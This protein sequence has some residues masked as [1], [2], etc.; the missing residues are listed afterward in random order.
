MNEKEHDV[1]KDLGD[2]LI[3]RR[4]TVEDA[5]ALA[6][7]NAK[8]HSD[9]GPE[10]PDNRVAVWVRDLMT[11]PHPTSGPGDFTIVE[12]TRK[13]KIVS[14]MN[15]IPQT[16]SYA[17]VPFGVGRPELVGTH[18][19]Y[20]KRG[21]VRAQFEVVHR[22]SAERGHKVQA[23]TG[24]PYYYRQFGYEMGLG[25]GGGRIGYTANIPMLEDD[26]EEP[27]IIRPAREADLPFIAELYAQSARRQLLSCLR[28]DP[29]WRYELL[30]KSKENLN[31]LELRLIEDS[32]G[33]PLGFLG[34]PF[35]LWGPT[36][37]V[38]IYELK[39]GTSWLQVTPSVLRYLQKEG[40]AYAAQKEGVEFQA[41]GFWTGSEHPVYEAIQDRLPRKRHPYAWYVRVPD[42]P[43]FLGHIKPVLE[44]R[45]AESVLVG[46]SGD[47]KL[48]MYR[49]GVKLA[50]EKGELKDVVAYTPEHINDGDVFFPGLTFLRLLFGYNDFWELEEMFPDC[51][52][53][54]DQG[55]ALTPILFPKQPSNLWPLA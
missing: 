17:G 13:G 52:A 21:L 28:D 49:N 54:N 31:K 19:D 37:V 35:S 42:L 18:P 4:A 38:Y 3:L 29:F 30:G 34:H 53:R 27:F 44:A 41:F 25:L 51:S 14:S 50:F 20:R 26:Q 43:G 5:E 12:D 40:Q 39:A 1:I 8:I 33:V 22:W 15:L 47:L 45:L 10:E 9:E 55:T 16:W 36:L 32:Q 48:C 24:I 11:Q 2:G 23:I 7:F 6:A 46:H